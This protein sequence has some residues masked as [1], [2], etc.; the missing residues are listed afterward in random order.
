MS[1][2]RLEPNNVKT[3]EAINRLENALVAKLENHLELE[4]D[5]VP[6]SDDEV[7]F[8]LFFFSFSFFLVWFGLVWFSLA[9]WLRRGLAVSSVRLGPFCLSRPQQTIEDVEIDPIDW[10]DVNFAGHFSR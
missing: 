3:M 9:L 2:S 6:E 10:A 1:R 7:L 8:R 4:A 5:D